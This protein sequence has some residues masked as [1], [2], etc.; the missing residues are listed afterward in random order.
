[1]TS[2]KLKPDQ[3]SA[4]LD[5]LSH[6]EVYQE[7][8]DFRQPGSLSRYGPPFSNDAGKPSTFP[9]LQALV[10][11]FVLTLPGLRNVSKKFWRDRV[12]AIIE[13]F[14]KAELS[15][16]YDKGSL[17]IR[18]TLA[19]AVSALIEYPVRGVFAG[20]AK[21]ASENAYIEYDTS[22]PEELAKAFRDFV[23]EAVYG[24]VIDDMIA[25]AAET[26][27]LSDHLPI[28]Q[29]AHEFILVK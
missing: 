1:M 16:S 8:R 19:T 9:S 13:D 20:L 15:E 26:D 6:H 10:S 4:L 17:G 21:P 3:Q 28:I 23:H 2:A 14:E 25:K 12:Y 22:K 27:Q 24:T 11:K 5:I 18:K 29:A 7:I